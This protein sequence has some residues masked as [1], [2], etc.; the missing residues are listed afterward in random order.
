[1]YNNN[2]SQ[3]IG[4][5][6]KIRLPFYNISTQQKQFKKR[7]ALIIGCERE[8]YPCDFT[9]LPISKISNSAYRDSK[10]DLE[11]TGSDCNV[12][13]LNHDPSFI[14]C[15]KIGT[16]HSSE[17]HRKIISDLSSS[18]PRLFNEAKKKY[19]DFSSELF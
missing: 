4:S 3:L 8:S 6:V 14:R 7:P 19:E 18:L 10:Y 9:Y 13:N 1:M 17:I 12:L 5:I 16:V 15:H 11:I 2:P